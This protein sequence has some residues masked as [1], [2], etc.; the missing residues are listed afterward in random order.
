VSQVALLTAV[1]VQPVPAVTLTEPVPP[2]PATDWLVAEI[3]YVHAAPACVTVKV[4]P[5]AVIVAVRATVL[6]LAAALNVT[7]PLPVPLAPPVTVS[8]VALLTAVHVQ[9][10]PAVTP[11]EP[12]PPPA[13]TDALVA[14]RV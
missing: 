12:V 8:H 4:C 9:P 11:T 6:V 14:D 5:P 3:E 2:A 10:V 7:V 13:T 1:H